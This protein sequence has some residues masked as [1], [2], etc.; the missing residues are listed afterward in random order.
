MKNIG[1]LHNM[2]LPRYCVTGPRWVKIVTYEDGILILGQNDI[3]CGHNVVNFSVWLFQLTV[4]KYLVA[5]HVTEP[6]S[7]LT[8]PCAV[9]KFSHFSSPP[10]YMCA[11]INNRERGRYPFRLELSI[12]LTK[13]WTQQVCN[14]SKCLTVYSTH[15]RCKKNLTG[16]L[17]W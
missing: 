4:F 10:R 7:L 11:I 16:I 1:F 5:S 15:N 17:I 9:I 3:F 13:C 12:L 8:E 6:G 2:L 14:V